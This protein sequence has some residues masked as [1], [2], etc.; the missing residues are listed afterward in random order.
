MSASGSSGLGW[1]I[2]FSTRDGRLGKLSAGIVF[3][4]RNYLA[5]CNRF[6]AGIRGLV[7]LV[8]AAW[9]V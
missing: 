2:P 7:L 4:G 8:G 5:G 9:L 3:Y 6:C 1:M